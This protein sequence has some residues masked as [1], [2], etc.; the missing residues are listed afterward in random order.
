MEKSKLLQVLRRLEK[1]EISALR[2]FLHSPF[3]NTREDVRRLYEFLLPSLHKPQHLVKEK[4]FHTLFPDRPNSDRDFHLLVS[5]LFKLVEKYLAT[6]EFIQDELEVKTQLMKS[7]RQ[8]HLPGHIQYPVGQLRRALHAS[9]VEDSQYYERQRDIYWEEYQMKVATDPSR[10][11]NLEE[12]TRTTEIAFFAQKMRQICL[13]TA[14]RSVYTIEDPLTA[15]L[16]FFD[17]LEAQELT[18][19]P[20]IGIYF[21]GYYLLRGEGEATHFPRFKIL[22]F[23]HSQQFS[24]TETRELYLLA[25]NFCVRQ[26]NEGNRGYFREMFELYQRGLELEVLLENGQL[27]RF[28]YHNAVASAIQIQSFDWARLM[29]VEYRDKLEAPHRE[30]AYRFNLARLEYEQANYTAALHLVAGIHFPDLLVNLA[31]KTITL[32]IYYQLAEFDLLEAHLNAMNNF[33]RRKRVLGYHKDNYL[34]IIRY[35]KKIMALK[36]YD[37]AAIQNLVAEIEAEEKLTEKR[38]LLQQLAAD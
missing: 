7:Y 10:K 1:R 17:Y 3:F 13:L 6:R 34:N 28:T 15:Q 12:L 2:K 16:P 22:L 9:E 11:L 14:Q 32:K 31:S 33:I 5:Y 35:T 36:P 18:Q 37:K 27:S 20:T 26:V 25:V 23:D 38:W 24:L 19:I 30:S 29:I 21:H 8:R 4:V